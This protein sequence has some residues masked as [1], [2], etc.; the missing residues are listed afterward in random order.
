MEKGRRG[1]TE[2]FSEASPFLPVSLS[3]FPSFFSRVPASAPV[4]FHKL[5]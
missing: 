5:D 4:G 2:M 1:E 3:P